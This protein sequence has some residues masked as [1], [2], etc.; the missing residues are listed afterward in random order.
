MGV[1]LPR[2]LKGWAEADTVILEKVLSQR[3][4]A[5]LKVVEVVVVDKKA[6]SG[7]RG[8]PLR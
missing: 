3:L 8:I 6:L 5:Y 7:V 1:R 4:R 2:S